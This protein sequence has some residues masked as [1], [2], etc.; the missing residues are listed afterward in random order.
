[1]DR[2]I[3]QKPKTVVENN[4]HDQSQNDHH[5]GLASSLWVLYYKEQYQSGFFRKVT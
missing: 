3:E 2:S 4:T 5:D 1:M